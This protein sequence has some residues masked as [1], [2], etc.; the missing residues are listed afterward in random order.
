VHAY[1]QPDSGEGMAGAEALAAFGGPATAYLPRCPRDVAARLAAAGVDAAIGG[2][3]DERVAA[4]S[5]V[6]HHA[7]IDTAQAALLA[8]RPQVVLPRQLD[9]IFNADALVRLG[10]AIRAAPANVLEALRESSGLEDRAREVADDLRRRGP[11]RP[12]QACLA[13]IDGSL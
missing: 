13:A 4:A 9:Q 8:G 2:G 12:A 10:V 11:W 1:L 3:L 7:G 6:L 5:V